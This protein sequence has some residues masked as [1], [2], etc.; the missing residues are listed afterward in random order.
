MPMDIDFIVQD[1][2]ALVRP[3]WKIATELSEAAQVFADACAT[4]YKAQTQEGPGDG[5]DGDGSSPSEEDIGD[6]DAPDMPD[7]DGDED[8]AS[9]DEAEV[10]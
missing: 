5:A 4:N 1:T 9:E 6:D 3:Q 8:G 10:C 2:Y 7:D